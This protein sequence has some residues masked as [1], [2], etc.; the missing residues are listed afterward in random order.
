MTSVGMKSNRQERV[1][2]LKLEREMAHGFGG[3]N[4]GSIERAA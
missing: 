2:L 3:E 4:P 1:T